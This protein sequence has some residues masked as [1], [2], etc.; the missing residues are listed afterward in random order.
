MVERLTALYG[1]DLT[2][3]TLIHPE[4]SIG[5]DISIG[6][7]TYLRARGKRIGQNHRR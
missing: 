2:P 5:E 1:E 6:A 4:T 3:W 7:G